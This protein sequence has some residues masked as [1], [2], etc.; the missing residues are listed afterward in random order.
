[1]G[2]QVG[3]AEVGQRP[4]PPIRQVQSVDLRQGSAPKGGHEHLGAVNIKAIDAALGVAEHL[5]R[6]LTV[7][8]D[9]LGIA[10]AGDQAVGLAILGA[11]VESR[12]R[13]SRRCP[14]SS[15]WPRRKGQLTGFRPYPGPG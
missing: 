8:A 9:Q 1:M 13:N 2:V 14:R 6:P 5:Q 15:R 12:R 11:Q 3:L 7:D 10:P 4:L